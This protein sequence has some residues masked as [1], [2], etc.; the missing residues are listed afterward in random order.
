MT[1]D[2]SNFTI[3]IIGGG[4]NATYAM[5]LLLR[6][7][8]DKEISVKIKI[9]VFE[10]TGEFGAG[11]THS[12]KTPDTAFLNRVAGQ[13]LLGAGR[14]YRPG[15]VEKL[16]NYRPTFLEWAEGKYLATKNGKY[17]FRDFDWPLRNIFGEA[18]KDSFQYCFQELNKI[19][20]IDVDLV[21]DEV[22]DVGRDEPERYEI[23]GTKN[24]YDGIDKILFVTGNTKRSSPPQ[25][26][27]KKL[28]VDCENNNAAFIENPLPLQ[29]QIVGTDKF[30]KIHVIGT[31]TTAIDVITYLNGS[32]NKS[33]G[34]NKT[35]DLKIFPIG[36]SGY[37]CFS[38]PINQKTLRQDNFHSGYVFKMSLIDEIR[39]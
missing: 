23:I 14:Y 39:K 17:K 35:G 24:V 18:M 16:E 12:T 6:E 19:E 1:V 29:E 5:D 21:V 3:A 2:M 30:E 28:Q 25:S 11:I 38:R 36:R 32:R 33:T 4:P 10:M 8:Y 20:N 7:F 31:A 22:V 26:W 9:L 27:Q 15:V 13:I 37:F 34:E